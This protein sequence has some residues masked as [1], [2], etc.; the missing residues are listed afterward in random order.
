MNLKNLSR[1]ELTEF[2]ESLGEKKFRAGQIWSWIYAKGITSFDDMTNLSKSLR[3]RLESAA[4]LPNLKLQDRKLS[5]VSGTCK[6]VW[7]LTDG[8]SIESVFIPDKSRRTV[9]LSSQA[10]CS[11]GCDFC[12]TGKMGWFRNLEVWEITG[13]VLSISREPGKNPTN[14]VVMGMG[15]PLLNYDNVIKALSIINDAG[16]IAI[17]HRKITLSTAGIVP[18]IRRYADEGHPF[19]LAVSLNATSQPQRARLMPVSRKYPLEELMDAVRYYSR[20]SKRRIT[21]EYVLIRGINDSQEDARRLK[22][23]VRNIPCKINLIAY[24]N[25]GGVYQSPPEDRIE[26]FAESLRTLRAP[27]TRRL[28]QGGDIQGACGQLASGKSGIGRDD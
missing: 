2:I 27:V 24:N 19:K 1:P 21:F 4:S 15:E 8:L 23:L 26:R 6:F 11:L 12:A 25:T 5:R 22:N 28:S 3:T 17:S 7:K 20:R 14:L 13:Q 9:C 10:G 16:G 18:A